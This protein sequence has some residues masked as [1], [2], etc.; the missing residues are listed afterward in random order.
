MTNLATAIA[1]GARGNR[2][3]PQNPRTDLG[4][5]A[6]AF[7]A[8]LDE[9]ETA[10][11]DARAAEARLRDFLS[12]VSHELRTPVAGVSVSAELLLAGDLPDDTRER[13]TAGLVTQSHRIA[14][15][16]DDLLLSA[17][18]AEPGTALHLIDVDLSALA[19]QQVEHARLLAPDLHIHLEP[20]APDI[21]APIVTADPARVAQILTNLLDNA[22]HATPPGGD[23]T[24]RLGRRVH[25]VTLTVDD[26]GLGVPSADRDR[27][28]DR[29]VRLD[30]RGTGTGLGLSISRAVAEA[31]GGTLR[32]QDPPTGGGARFVLELPTSPTPPPPI[33]ATAEP[34]TGLG[35]ARS[36]SNQF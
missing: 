33:E 30:R 35:P 13:L 5:T 28:F 4:R 36:S 27:V 19:A 15:L 26:T 34:A 24:V 6:T 32:Y 20:P 11:I 12:E 9:L 2:L 31:H 3:H 17:R 8:M 1:A 25:T 23:I 18:L 21:T 7:D 14:R 16:V 22:R 10:L 29:F